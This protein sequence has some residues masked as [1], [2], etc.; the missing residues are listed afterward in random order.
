MK[1]TQLTKIQTALHKS[2][3]AEEPGTE[4]YRELLSQLDMVR[5]MDPEPSTPPA[6]SAGTPISVIA[7][8]CWAM[9]QHSKIDAIRKFREITNLD[10]RVAKDHIENA[11]ARYKQP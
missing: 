9:N 5:R 4:R 10:L 6:A 7:A 2:L 1:H 3:C 11:E 8:G